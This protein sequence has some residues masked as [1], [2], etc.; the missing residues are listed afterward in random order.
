MQGFEPRDTASF[1]GR[2][3]CGEE[4]M[5]KM[6]SRIWLLFTVEYLL[7]HWNYVPLRND[8]QSA[9]EKGLPILI[10]IFSGQLVYFPSS[11]C[12]YPLRIHDILSRALMV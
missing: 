9:L 1:I 5:V 12:T 3:L 2:H 4:K 8:F 11:L 6:H 10:K 7:T